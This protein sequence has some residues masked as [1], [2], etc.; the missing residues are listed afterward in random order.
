MNRWLKLTLLLLLSVGFSYAISISL[1]VAANA[2]WQAEARLQAESLTNSLLVTMESNYS[3]L[4]A[5]GTLVESVD[6]LQS[7]EFKNAIDSLFSKQNGIFLEDF[8]IYNVIPNKDQTSILKLEHLYDVNQVF[9]NELPNLEKG[10]SNAFIDSVETR[11]GEIVVHKPLPD[12]DNIL[13][14]ITYS[15]DTDSGAKV[16]IAA[17]NFREFLASFI[18]VYVP[19]RVGLELSGVFLDTQGNITV[20]KTKNVDDFHVSTKVVTATGEFTISWVFDSMFAGGPNTDLADAVLQAGIIITIVLVLF[21]HFLLSQNKVISLKVTEASTEL[22]EKEA[23]LIKAK[24]VAEIATKTITDKEQQLRNILDLSPIGFCITTDDKLEYFNARLKRMMDVS[25]GESIA[26]L[27]FDPNE[28]LYLQTK[29]NSQQTLKDYQLTMTGHNDTRLET[30]ATF[31]KIEFNGK[32]SLLGWFYDVTALKNL[33]EELLEANKIAEE[34]ATAKSNFLANMSHEIRTPMNAIIGMTHLALQTNLNSKQQNY[35]EKV[36]SSADALLGIIDDILDFSKIE[37]GK[38]EMESVPFSL[39]DVLENL[40][41]LIGLKADE[42]HLELLFDVGSDVPDNLLGDPLRLGQVLTN[43]GNNAVKFTEQGQVLLKVRLL[44][45]SDNKVVLQFAVED[46]GIGLT[47]KQQARLFQSFSQADSTTSRKYGGTG[48]GLTISKKITE[49]MGGEITV[50]SEYGKGSTFKFTATLSKSTRDVENKLEVLDTVNNLSVLVIED[51]HAAADIIRELLL[52]FNFSPTVLHSGEEAIRLIEQTK[53]HFDVVITDWDMP[54][55]D[56]V[57]T[58]QRIKKLTD[59]LPIIMVTAFDHRQAKHLAQADLFT[60]ILPKPLLSSTFLEAIYKSLGFAYQVNRADRNNHKDI[61]QHIIQLRGANILLVEDNEMNQELVLDLTSEQDIQVTVA[62]N[63]KEAIALLQNQHFDGILMDC[64]MPV[65]DGYT[66]SRLIRQKPELENVPIIAMTANAMPSDLDEILASGMNDRITKPLNVADMFKIMAQW[67]TP[68]KPLQNVV[69]EEIVSP[70]R[71][72]FLKD[73]K[74]IDSDYALEILE[75][76]QKLY[77][78]LL[79][80]FF[81]SNSNFEQQLNKAI[82]D[83][84]RGVD[85]SAAIRCA[86]TLKGTAGNIGA[87]AL[88]LSAAKLEKAY[89]ANQG[90]TEGLVKDVLTELDIV[91]QGIEANI[92]SLQENP[93]AKHFDKISLKPLLCELVCLIKDYNT[94]AVDVCEKIDLILKGTKLGVLIEKLTRAINAYD[95]DKALALA[96][97]LEKKV[98]EPE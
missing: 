43:L 75:Q 67:I 66:A 64:Q 82:N 33:T 2:T 8:A 42:K 30:L 25:L 27:Y 95:F 28:R 90:N 6:D 52:S 55:L 48:L 97:E 29:L 98:N 87:K 58:A 91:L 12:N 11:F 41:N 92:M 18:T 74:G 20:L 16:L 88:Q 68:S 3:P 38:L 45:E 26:P 77:I 62:S 24:E 35:I 47:A 71:Y 93:V 83:T 15:V 81:N 37:A 80:L 5:L 96:D 65:M 53:A 34:A 89:N 76:N 39:E 46:T 54:G 70:E 19:D 36:K 63:G 7:Y 59:D 69:A 13:L 9:I 49:M 32:P 40:A 56:G 22:K 94:S 61:Q 85:E 44:S 4:L 10:I 60:D 72:D 31:S 50:N 14:P 17:L 78:K 57:K 21:A 79:K 84:S 86:H 23:Q 1:K 73:L 51:N